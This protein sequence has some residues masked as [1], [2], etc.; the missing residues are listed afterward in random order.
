[1]VGVGG[2]GEVWLV[3]ELVGGVYGCVGVLLEVC[4]DGSD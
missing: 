1:M 4:V 3:V 2:N